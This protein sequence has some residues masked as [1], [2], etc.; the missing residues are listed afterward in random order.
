MAEAS[1]AGTVH[2]RAGEIASRAVEL[3]ARRVGDAAIP[4]MRMQAL[5]RD[6]SLDDVRRVVL[7]TAHTRLPVYE[8]T[9]DNVVGYVVIRDL[10]GLAWGGGEPRT[11]DQILRPVILFPETKRAV[12]A[13]QELQQKRTHLA[14]VVDETGVVVGLVTIEDLL[15]E[16]VGDIFSEHEKPAENV[17][18]EP[19][20]TWLVQGTVPIRDL[21]RQ[22]GLEL[23]EGQGYTTIAGLV[24]VLLGRIPQVGATTQSPDGSMIEVIEASPRR[25]RA[26]R[27][28]PAPP[29]DKPED[30][31]AR[32]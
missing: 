23:P 7:E 18:R 8:G 10:I 13:L 3:G 20:G 28:K 5:P 19:G 32:P 26:V 25:V 2:A 17:R 29:L 15:E 9:L 27:L 16:I 4:R 14:I 1:E 11:L 6:A 22:L 31:P 21:N 12:E 30:P 24:L